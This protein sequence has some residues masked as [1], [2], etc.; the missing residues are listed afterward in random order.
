MKNVNCFLFVAILLSS[1]MVFSLVFRFFDGGFFVKTNGIFP[2]YFYGSKRILEK[3]FFSLFLLSLFFPSLSLSPFRSFF[4]CFFSVSLS[5]SSSLSVSVSLSLSPF[6][7]FCFSIYLCVS[8]SLSLFPFV[9]CS[10]FPS[11]I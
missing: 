11:Q 7:S 2:R 6:P 3:T 9:S 5:V 8:L 4:L 1:L 10:I